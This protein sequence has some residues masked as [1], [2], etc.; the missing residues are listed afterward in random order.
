MVKVNS[1]HFA[2]ELSYKAGKIKVDCKLSLPF[3]GEINFNLEAAR[4]FKYQKSFSIDKDFPV[5][6]DDVTGKRINF[7]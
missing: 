7:D 6:K 4:D 3:S 1:H 5:I 2:F